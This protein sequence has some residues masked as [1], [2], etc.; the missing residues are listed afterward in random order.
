MAPQPPRM[1]TLI[2]WSGAGHHPGR[3]AHQGAPHWL[4]QVRASEKGNELRWRET[5]LSE[6]RAEGA[7][8]ELP[9]HLG[10]MTVRSWPR[11]LTWLPRWLTC[12]K[13]TL[14]NAAMTSA[15]PT[16]GSA[17]LTPTAGP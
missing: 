4:H 10:T 17:G 5:G 12:T 15:P 9:M 11:S 7:G 2:R 6:H 13:P 16:T 14:D 1:R 3:P 8:R